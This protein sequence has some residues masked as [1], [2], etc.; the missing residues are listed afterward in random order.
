MENKVRNYLERIGIKD[1]PLSAETLAKLQTAHYRSVPYENLD[2]LLGRPIVLDV[3]AVYKKVVEEHRGG[4]CFELNGLYGWLLSSLGFS[5]TE[6][7]ARFLKD[8]KEIPM[9]RHR[10]L[11]VEA[12]GEKY[13]CD[14]GV[15]CPTPI[16]CLKL[17]YGKVQ[18]IDGTDYRFRR[19]ALLKNVLEYRHHGNWESY[20]SFG[21]DE[22]FPCDYTAPSLYCELS[23]QS[24]FNKDCM[25]HIWT[26]N[27]R[28]SLEGNLLKHFTSENV[29]L[30]ELTSAEELRSALKEE[31]G[32]KV[33]ESEA[34][35]L[36]E[37]NL[38]VKQN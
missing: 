1:A 9:G 2:I 38:S 5:Y 24:P 6:R 28:T 37:K 3:D 27:G 23:D 33:T 34:A 20:Y 19:D 35:L 11:L 10:I 4:Y 22:N 21:D 8:E 29:E 25:A 26:E 14:V 32:L 16:E 13:V 18:S 7:L 30:R 36:F 12:E 15:G 31:F 17:E